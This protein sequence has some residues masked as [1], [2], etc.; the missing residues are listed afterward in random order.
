MHDRTVEGQEA[1]N[2]RAPVRPAPTDAILGLQQTAGNRAVS[3]LVAIQRLPLS[4]AQWTHIAKGEL[5][6]G[7]KLVG[8]HWTGDDEAIAEKNGTSQKGPDDRGVYEEGVQTVA[9]SYG[10]KKNEPIKKSNPSTFWPD[11]WSEADIKDAIA[12]GGSARNNV[13]EVSTKASKVE[14]RGMSLFVNPDSVFPVCEA[15]EDDGGG[16][17][18]RKGGRG[19]G[20]K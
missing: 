19:K 2:R 9:S 7:G 11:G 18:G 20:R 6:E 10:K 17:G 8:Y 15:E 3:R 16:K 5:R 12:N 14:A 1:A 13:S 4:A